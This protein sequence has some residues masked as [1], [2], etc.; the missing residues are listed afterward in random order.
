MASDGVVEPLA[1]AMGAVT[2]RVGS[3]GM[4]IYS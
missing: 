3:A 4:I 2:L 1:T